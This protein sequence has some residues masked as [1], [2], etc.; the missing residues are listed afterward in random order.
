VEKEVRINRYCLPVPIEGAPLPYSCSLSCIAREGLAVKLNGVIGMYDYL[1]RKRST[2]KKKAAIG[3][4]VMAAFGLGFFFG[5]FAVPQTVIIQNITKTLIAGESG[6]ELS[7][8]PISYENIMNANISSFA[9]IRIPA[10]DKDEKGVITVL[11]VQAV[12]GSGRILTNI[13]KLLFWV[14][15]QNSIRKA[16]A[17]AENVTGLNVTNY[18]IVYTIQANASV[19]GGPS[20]GAAITIATIAA[21]AN[22][23]IDDSV[24]IT[25]SVNHDGTIGPVGGIFEKAVV[26]KKFGADTML[27][28]LTQSTQVTYKTR[29]YCEKIGWMDFC[30]T[31]TY[32]VKLDIEQ[33]V[34]IHVEEIMT[35]Q[36]AMGFMLVDK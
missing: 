3:L 2:W 18:D 30:T 27:V 14:D 24:M 15:T 22:K 4:L 8:E 17:V 25:G 34:G 1:M 31:E 36:D 23:S 21:L 11:T 6:G 9:A 5:N 7:M 35:I 16:N 29:Q 33:D 19:I 26:S 13:D 28:P 32:P 20:A 10:V 12:P